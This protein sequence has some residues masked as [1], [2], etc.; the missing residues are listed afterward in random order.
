M[1]KKIE[2]PQRSKSPNQT[3]KTRRKLNKLD[4]SGPMIF[5]SASVASEVVPI[6]VGPKAKTN[7]RISEKDRA[8]SL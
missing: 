3:T 6:K 5:N 7:N 4:I 8:H 2:K 1:S